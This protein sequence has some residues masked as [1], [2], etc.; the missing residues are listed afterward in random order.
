MK[1]EREYLL[2]LIREARD[3]ILAEGESTDP[4]IQFPQHGWLNRVKPLLDT[5]M[6]SQG[7]LPI[8]NI[9]E[10]VQAYLH[11]YEGLKIS[12]IAPPSF[13]EFEEKY[14]SKRGYQG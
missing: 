13:T 10:A 5:S 14:W 4:A 6:G 12:K 9:D 11:L 3:L 7:R 1:T 8:G 2:D